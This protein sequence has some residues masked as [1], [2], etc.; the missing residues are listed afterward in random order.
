MERRKAWLYALVRAAELGE[1]LLIKKILQ[2]F[3][4]KNITCEHLLFQLEKRHLPTVDYEKNCIVDHQELSITSSIN[5]EN[6]SGWLAVLVGHCGVV[7]TAVAESISKPF[8][9]IEETQLV[10]RG[11]TRNMIVTGVIGLFVNVLRDQAR[12]RDGDSHRMTGVRG[13]RR[14]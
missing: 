2:V 13:T 6:F 9:P 12:E 14:A 4:Q 5:R 3:D 1:N 11:L 10:G 8:L 7:M